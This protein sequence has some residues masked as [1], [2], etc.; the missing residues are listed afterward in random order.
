MSLALLSLTTYIRWQAA[1]ER[2]PGCQNARNGQNPANSGGYLAV[3]LASVVSNLWPR[4]GPSQ[5]VFAEVCPGGAGANMGKRV[6][7]CKKRRVTHGRESHH[8]AVGAV[9]QRSAPGNLR[10]GNLAPWLP[11]AVGVLRFSH[12]FPRFWAGCQR[13]ASR[14]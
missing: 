14:Q 1:V 9:V 12:V 2:S 10:N 11:L 4:F 5:C 7:V 8:A 13:L 6:G 3:A